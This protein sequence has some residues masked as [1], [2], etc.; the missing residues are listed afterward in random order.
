MRIRDNNKL[1]TIALVV[2]A[3]L[4]A[5][6][7][8]AYIV[9]PYVVDGQ[10]METTL[11]NSD[12][13]L[14]DKLP[15]AFAHFSHPYIPHRG[16]IIVFNQSNLPGFSGTKQLIKRVVG[17]PGDR[18]V[19][20]DG[21]ITIYNK[22]S[23]DGFNPDSAT[24]YKLSNTLTLGIVDTT[25]SKD[26]IFVLGDNRNNSEDSRYFGPVNI[27]QIV[28]KLILRIMPFDKTQRF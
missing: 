27:N 22:S 3:I 14:V 7:T 26:Q 13:L 11:Q 23:P 21:S 5:L 15:L 6:F 8:K 12:R 1:S 24:G 10:S 18:V 4:L 20:K 17:L 25:L 28:G 2:A 9:Q 19:I 16:D